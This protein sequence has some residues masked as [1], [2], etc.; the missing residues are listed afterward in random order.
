MAEDIH[1]TLVGWYPPSLSTTG[2]RVIDEGARV[3]GASE[4]AN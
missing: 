4:I 1:D 2:A 3:T